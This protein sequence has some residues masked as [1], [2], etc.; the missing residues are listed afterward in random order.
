MDNNKSE[1]EVVE[2]QFQDDTLK[3]AKNIGS[4]ID[5]FYPSYNSTAEDLPTLMQKDSLNLLNSFT[6][7]KLCECTVHNVEDRLEYFSARMEKLFVTAYAIK[8]TVCYGIVSVNGVTSLLIGIAPTSNNEAIRLVIEGLLPG[9]KIEKY[10]GGFESKSNNDSSGSNKQKRDNKSPRY[11]GSISGIPS[12]KVDGKFQYK[13][14]S[15][16]MRSLNGQEYTIMVL[17]RPIDEYQIQQKI[18]QAIKIQDACFAIS[19]RTVGYQYGISRGNTHTETGSETDGTQENKNKGVNVNAGFAG[20]AGGAV[21][22]AA[23]GS[24]VPGIGTAAGAA[25]GGLV[26]FIAGQQISISRGESVGKSHSKTKGYSDAVSETINNNQSI[27]GEIQ[28]GFAVELMNMSQASVERLKIGRSR[29]MWETVVSFSSNEK[30]AAEIIQGSLYS[31]ISSGRPDILPPAVFSYEDKG[32]NDHEPEQLIIPR[33]FFNSNDASPLCSL[34]TSEELCGLCTIPADNTVG[35]TI[36]N[37]KSFSINSPMSKD[38]VPI[39]N[40]L[41]YSRELSNVPFGLSKDDVNKHVFVCGMTGYGKTNTVKKIL[42]SFE[43]VP[44]L[45]IEP[46]KKEY[47]NLKN[48]PTVY[49]FGRPEINC[50]RLNPFYIMPGVSPQQHIDLLKDLFS[51]SFAFYGPMPYIFEKC[52]NR[53]YMKKGWNLTLGFHPLL[54][55]SK[56]RNNEE[57]FSEIKNNYEISSHK[58]LFP[59]MQD[60]KSELAT[61][62]DKELTYEGD[63]K[64]N[65]KS[66]IESRIDSLCVGSKGYM[67]NT[68]EIVDFEQ[69]LKNNAVIELEGLA[70]DSDKAFALGLLIIYI[71]EFRQTEKELSNSDGLKHILVV[72]EAHRLLKNVSSEHAEDIG[73]PKGKSVEHFTNLLAEMRSYGQG[74]IVAEQ[75]P[76]KLAPDVIK[77]SSV[78]IVH[79]IAAKDDQ[80]I[81]AN[82]IGLTSDDALSL[83]NNGVGCALCHKDGMFEPVNVRIAEVKSNNVT[84]VKL[85][86]TNLKQKLEDIT[87][88]II[89][90]N[91]PEHVSAWAV[92]LLVSLMYHPDEQIIQRGLDGAIIVFERL[93]KSRAIATIP[94]VD[95]SVCI[96][97]CLYESVISLMTSGVFSS[98]ALPKDE[99]CKELSEMLVLPD[100]AR[101]MRISNLLEK[102]YMKKPERKAIETVAA[103]VSGEYSKRYDLTAI[104]QDFLLLKSKE[105]SSEVKLFLE[106]A[107]ER[108]S[109]YDEYC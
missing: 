68:S 77:N 34:V 17:C 106:M 41:E 6:F 2:K 47:R 98:R 96:K 58:Y 84:D 22:G 39:G 78:K 48:L 65:I 24:F 19:K 86:R 23:V 61:Y 67:F 35:F 38:D 66:A 3:L 29:G 43:Q 95:K 21:A 42:E 109:S 54:I 105:F 108:R 30:I 87:C 20:A 55:N 45:V 50:V 44:Y 5:E 46:A 51:A 25:A 102:F 16:L 26:G 13:D 9:I 53:I 60:L 12:L 33:N 97:R 89:N 83:G 101:I 74:V 64:G 8:Q 52:I 37:S 107:E 69:I 63:V 28:N 18:D 59:T 36:N 94:N 57:L 90:G 70:D 73:N 79:R 80:E 62:I 72:E 7:Y 40:V 14:I 92:K 15:S 103:L 1:S 49:T 11:L 71:N 76:S 56:V 100:T 82:T 93:L 88:S 4:F 85:Y 75:I 32:N 31:E 81:I 10:D 99:L 91:L 104:S 27:S